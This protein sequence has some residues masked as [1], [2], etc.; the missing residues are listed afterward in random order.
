MSIK[1]SCLGRQTKVPF[2]MF[3]IYR[4]SV[5]L[6]NFGSNIDSW[7]SYGEILIFDLWPW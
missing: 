7:L 2:D 6:Q 5:C 1:A 4:F 3:N